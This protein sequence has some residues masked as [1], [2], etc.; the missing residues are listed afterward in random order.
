MDVLL[1]VDMQVGLFEGD[2]P[3]HDAD[4]VVRRIN[5]VAGAVRQKGG[6]VVFIQHDGPEGDALAPGTPGWRILPSLDRIPSDPVVRK[7]TCD[8]FYETTLQALLKEIGGTRLFVT[9]CATDF[10][11]DTTVRS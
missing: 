1:V 4:G 5:R 10:C 9:G 11:V 8:P 6:A 7:R 3:R 2:L